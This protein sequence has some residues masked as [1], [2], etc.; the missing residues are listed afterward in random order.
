[1]RGRFPIVPLAV[2]AGALALV[3]LMMK[4][5]TEEEKKQDQQKPPPGQGSTSPDGAPGPQGYVMPSG[6]YDA[7]VPR[8]SY[9]GP[10]STYFPN[11]LFQFH[12]SGK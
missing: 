11:P 10:A 12:P 3:W 5:K 7:Y 8:P 4:P 6:P 2:G 1:M 9:T